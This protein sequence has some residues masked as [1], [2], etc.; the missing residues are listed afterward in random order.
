[1]KKNVFFVLAAILIAVIVGAKVLTSVSAQGQVPTAE[2]LHSNNV[3]RGAFLPTA[4][5]VPTQVVMPPAATPDP[6]TIDGQETI[7][8]TALKAGMN[9]VVSTTNEIFFV[10]KATVDGIDYYQYWDSA[11]V[12]GRYPAPKTDTNGKLIWGGDKYVPNLSLSKDEFFNRFAFYNYGFDLDSIYTLLSAPPLI[13]ND[14][15]SA[16]MPTP[17]IPTKQP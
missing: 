16:S 15:F 12:W 11:L 13:L 6:S 2:I 5:A 9:I 10:K 3:A 4:T 1:M 7:W 14:P 17:A 8:L